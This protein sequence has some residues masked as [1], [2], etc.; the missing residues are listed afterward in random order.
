MPKVTKEVFDSR[1]FTF[2]G[3]VSVTEKGVA[4]GFSTSNYVKIDS[5]YKLDNAIYYV[6]FTTGDNLTT[7]SQVF[8]ICKV[9]S[10]EGKSDNLYAYN[11]GTSSG[12][13]LLT[14]ATNTTYWVKVEVNGTTKTYSYSTDGETYETLTTFTDSGMNTTANYE[15]RFGLSSYD[16]EQP[17]L[18]TIDLGAFKITSLD[19]EV[20]FDN[21][22]ITVERIEPLLHRSS[23]SKETKVVYD[24]TDF[25]YNGSIVVDKNGIASG[26]N[27]T[28]WI[29][30]PVSIAKA[31][32]STVT[33]KGQWTYGTS[34]GDVA[35]MWEFYATSKQKFRQE[36]KSDGGSTQIY[37]ADATRVNTTT[38]DTALV[39]GDVIDIDV[40]IDF[41]NNTFNET[42]TVNGSRTYTINATTSY[43]STTY[44]AFLLGLYYNGSSRSL[45]WDGTIDLKTIEVTVDGKTIIKGSKTVTVTNQTLEAVKGD[46]THGL[47]SFNLK[48]TNKAV[49]SSTGIAS[50]FYG[51]DDDSSFAGVRINILDLLVTL[52]KADSWEIQTPIYTFNNFDTWQSLFIE[53]NS[54]FN[55][56]VRNN[57]KKLTW[58]ANDVLISEDFTLE[59]ALVAGEFYWFRLRYTGS[60]YELEVYRHVPATSTVSTYDVLMESFS[61]SSTDKIPVY[62]TSEK[63]KRYCYIGC[64]TWIESRY[65][66]GTADLRNLWIVADDTVLFDGSKEV[67]APKYKAFI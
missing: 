36:I 37:H 54:N 61:Y 65:L 44:S 7:D 11:W 49:I 13:N 29:G 2:V 25:N 14:M 34:S 15:A 38:F 46:I 6:K 28:S 41:A 39:A 58:E 64:N 23:I 60:S 20:I 18:G 52:S 63:Y 40:T 24:S 9:L 67:F 33:I 19:G 32:T 35:M 26:F 12:Y 3:D 30:V 55:F 62:S 47:E 50:G 8:H 59:T 4:S 21:S 51:N 17:W 1:R 22:I 27:T 42:L 56:E 66:N 43:S 53:G 57:G 48:T 5:S 31:S 16:L 10:I 45:P